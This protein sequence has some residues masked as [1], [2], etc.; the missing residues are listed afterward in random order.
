MTAFAGT[1]LF[2]VLM[3]GVLL[4]MAFHTSLPLPDEEGVEISFNYMDTTKSELPADKHNMTPVASGS[5]KPNKTDKEEVIED[6]RETLSPS[7]KKTEKIK[8]V[9]GKIRKSIV[10]T[11]DESTVVHKAMN[12]SAAKSNGN[13]HEIPVLADK[14]VNYNNLKEP[15]NQSNKAGKE[16]GISFDLGGRKAR[17]LP[18]PSFNSS[19]DGKIVVSVKVNTEGKVISATAGDKGTTITQPSLFKQAENAARISLFVHDSNAP[20]AQRGT[21]TYFVVKQK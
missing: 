17:I 13:K 16:N 11:P 4:I 7:K 1:L 15:Q 9:S 6:V 3:A 10:E 2:H 5:K 14:P 21:I 19:E 12:T 8:P 18:K 20:E